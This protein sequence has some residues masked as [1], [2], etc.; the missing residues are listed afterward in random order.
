[1]TGWTT[2]PLLAL[3]T[4][5]TG[6]DPFSDR[7]VSVAAVTFDGQGL[8]TERWSTLVDPGIDIPAA[9]SAVHGITT[10]QARDEGVRPPKA[11]QDLAFLLS[12]FQLN[13][14]T[15]APVVA[16]NVRYDWPLILA[17]AARL[18]VEF[19]VGAHLL[20]PLVIDRMVRPRG[21]KRKLIDVLGHYDVRVNVDEATAA[22]G[23][24]AD[25]EAAGHVM[26]QIVAHHPHLRDMSLTALYL[27]QVHAAETQRQGFAEW[28]RRNRDASFEGSPPGWPIPVAAE[29]K[30]KA[31]KPAAL[32]A[33]DIALAGAKAF[34]NLPSTEQR[35]LRY[36]LTHA[37][38]GGRAKSANDLTPRQLHTVHEHLVD[39][40]ED[41]MGYE[42]GAH[43]VCFYWPD[44]A[45]TTVLWDQLE[46]EVT[47]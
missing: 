19:P 1:M 16:F 30:P 32:N 10:E 26:R 29:P 31:A 24:L 15:P 36:A 7:I 6:L 13:W 28:M 21:G 18:G 42:L 25:A 39:L 23:A 8:V 41:R 46:A 38:T 27:A 43:G 40:A 12:G 47:S 9:A 33:K 3:D 45:G 22:H 17:E 44:G 35:R 2:R 37:A 20:D 14:R 5:S 34:P 4:E 11:L